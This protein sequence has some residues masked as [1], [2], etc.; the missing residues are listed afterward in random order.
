MANQTP[1]SIP[2]Q[3][4]VGA[5]M[6]LGMLGGSMIVAYSGFTTSPRRGGTPTFVPVPEAYVIAGF[7]YLMSVLAMIA[8]L[9]HRKISVRA[10][11][12]AIGVYF[13]AAAL[14]VVLLAP[15]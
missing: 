9:R 1:L 11:A 2:A 13:V 5:L 4:S 14:L 10:I 12:A 15:A 8:L 7:L 3:I 6:V